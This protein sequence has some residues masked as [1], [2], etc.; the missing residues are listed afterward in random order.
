MTN[1]IHSSFALTFIHVSP[2]SYPPHHSNRVNTI[3]HPHLRTKELKC[4]KQKAG[5]RGDIPVQGGNTRSQE[6]PSSVES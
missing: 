4:E 1:G 5:L 2:S 3:T 6:L